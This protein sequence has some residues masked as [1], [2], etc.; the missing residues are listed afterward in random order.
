MVATWMVESES[1]EIQERVRARAMVTTKPG[2]GMAKLGQQIAQLMA[3][4]T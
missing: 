1:E 2:E 3:V 4:L